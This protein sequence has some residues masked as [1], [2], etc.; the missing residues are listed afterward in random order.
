MTFY[1]DAEFA[2]I[3]ATR[4]TIAESDDGT[5]R[6]SEVGDIVVDIHARHGMLGV[7]AV[8]LALARHHSASLSVIAYSRTTSA[9]VVLDEFEQHKLDQIN[10]ESDDR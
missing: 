2:A 10:A 7:T 3:A 8:V 1:D 5:P 4:L 9:A 6:S